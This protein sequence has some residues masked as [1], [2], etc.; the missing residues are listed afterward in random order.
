MPDSVQL[1]GKRPRGTVNTATTPRVSNSRVFVI[2]KESRITYLIDSGAEISVFPRKL[3]HGKR[4]LSTYTLS[5]ANGTDIR[6]YGTVILRLNFGLRRDFVWNFIVADIS[7]PIIGADFLANFDLLV[8]VRNRRIWD[9]KTGLGTIAVIATGVAPSVQVIRGTSRYHALLREFH[10]ITRPDGVNRELKHATEHH[11][12]TL[13]GPP[14]TCK[15]RRLAPDKLKMARQEFELMMQQG[16]IRPSKSPWSSPLHL[17][18]KND[19]QWRPCGDYRALNARTIPD[20]YPIR[21]IEDFAHMLRGRKI[22]SKIDLVRAYHQI[23]VAQEDIEK[24]ALSTPFGLFEFTRMPFGLRNA[25]QTFQRFID[26]VLRSLEFCYPY[27]DDILIASKDEDEHVI[28][29]T[30]LFGR[31]QEYGVIINPSKCKFGVSEVDFLGFRVNQQGTRPLPGKVEAILNLPQPTTAKELRRYLGMFNF[32][33]RFVTGASSSQAP[34]TTLLNGNKKGKQTVK[35]TPQASQAFAETKKCLA[36]ATLLAHPEP[37]APLALFTDASDSAIGATLQQKIGENWE[38]LGFFSRKLSTAETKYSAFDREM[39]AVYA[40]I[41]Y[42]RH[43]V[44]AKTFV[45]FTDHKPLTYAFRQKPEKCSPRQFRHL[46]YISQFTTDIRHIAGDNNVVADALSRICEINDC[47]KIDYVKLAE[48]QENDEEI[49]QYLEED[50]SLLLRRLTI[51]ETNVQ[52]YCD[53]NSVQARPY[54]TKA[55]RRAAFNVIHNLSHPGANT[56]IKLITQRFVW[57]KIKADCRQ[58]TRECMACQRTKVSRHVITSPGVFTPPTS[59][60]DHIHLD[61]VIMPYSEGHRYLLTIIDRFTRWLEA[62]PL[63]DIEATTVAK[64]LYEN[65]ICRFGCPTKVT[66]DRG[67]QFESDLFKQLTKLTGTTHIHTTAY[68]PAANGMIERAHRQLKVALKC[69][70]DDQW[71]ETLPTVL[72]GIRTAWRPDLEATSAELVYGESLRLP[73]EF[74]TA[75]TKPTA[76]T[77]PSLVRNLRKHFED[78]RPTLPSRHGE[79]R[80]FVFKE[81]KDAKHVFIRRGHT[82]GILQTAY[83]GPYRVLR[84]GEKT[85]DVCVRGKKCTVSIERVK[86]AFVCAETDSDSQPTRVLTNTNTP[87]TADSNLNADQTNRYPLQQT[88]PSTPNVYVRQTRS[89]R[90]VRFPSRYRTN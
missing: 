5:A 13:P 54:V 82:T 42:F 70:Q 31:L 32:Y 89:G 81:L 68:H 57:P 27:L 39:L 35:W 33:R 17:V 58:W 3:T 19:Q 61:I 47:N 63:Q 83:E 86:P 38:P 69:H 40:A 66:T 84:R 76:D 10:A 18:A 52:I 7:K 71:T 37:N 22:F 53:V 29:L 56:T 88:A 2:D 14:V 50:S 20:R 23:P 87:S 45:V 36:E 64:A 65:W 44:E 9:R 30:T 90:K 41:R 77:P 72:L 80:T 4:E 78:L 48:S 60:F 25:A 46:D 51:P 79:K 28:H 6:T 16:I 74:L 11:I 85:Y 75:T 1:A 24:T 59:R 49:Q 62:I 55:F 15:P 43:M 26:E 67:T 12:Q 34:L 21:H 8:D 73:G